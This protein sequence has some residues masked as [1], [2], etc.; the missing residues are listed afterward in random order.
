V[1]ARRQDH[2]YFSDKTGE[3]ELT[4]RTADASAF[5]TGQDEEQTLTKLGPGYR[6]QPHGA[7]FQEGAVD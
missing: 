2:A 5:N 3:Y 6:Y 4:V 7:G 1:V